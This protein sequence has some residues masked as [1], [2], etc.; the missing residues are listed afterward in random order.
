MFLGE[1]GVKLLESGAG[2][3]TKNYSILAF[4]EL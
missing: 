4:S 1:S 3:S 2:I